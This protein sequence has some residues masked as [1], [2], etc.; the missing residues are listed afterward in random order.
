M[1]YT[2]VTGLA[3]RKGKR[4]PMASAVSF[5]E[6]SYAVNVNVDVGTVRQAA[7]DKRAWTLLVDMRQ[8]GQRLLQVPKYNHAPQPGD[9]IQ[10]IG[11]QPLLGVKINDIDVFKRPAS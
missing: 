7:W 8:T 2:L 6:P 9:R 5:V 10:L 11:S 3:K 4:N 1:G